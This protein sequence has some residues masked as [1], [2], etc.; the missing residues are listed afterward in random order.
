MENWKQIDAAFLRHPFSHPDDVKDMLFVVRAQ[1]DSVFDDRGER[2]LDAAASWWVNLF[3]HG[4]PPLVQA[5]AQQ[6]ETLSHVMFSGITHRPALELAGD[7]IALPGSPGGSVFFSDNGS[8]AIEVAMKLAWHYCKQNQVDSSCFWAF[9]GGYHGDTLGAMSAGERDV[10]VQ[11]YLHLLAPVHFLE[12]NPKEGYDLDCIRR[13]IQ[14]E[15]PAAFLYEPLLQGAGG[16]RMQA[17]QALL[18]LLK[19][20]KEEGVLLIADEVFTGFGRTGTTLASEQ[21][22][23][24]DLLCL[25]KALTGG[26]MPLG[27]TLMSQE[28]AA[29]TEQTDRNKRFYHGHSYTAN[30]MACAL[31]RETLREWKSPTWQNAFECLKQNH[32]ARASEWKDR[33]PGSDARSL[34]SVLAINVPR[35]TS[36]YFYTDSIGREM[37]VA[38]LK[39]GILFRPLGNVLYTVPPLCIGALELER[40]YGFM[41]NMLIQQG[42]T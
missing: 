32:H 14:Q 1:G 2:Y 20:L 35:K 17:P 42:H 38:G 12:Y 36:G 8:T 6:S 30:P 26:F 15:R 27:A 16:M 37:Y 29:A 21:L 39:A 11:P 9:S 5:L 28:I 22:I 13:R 40:I 4:H 31:A 7:L 25:S 24:P 3:G 19:L 23:Q 33:F 10:F 41:E 34:G 18:P